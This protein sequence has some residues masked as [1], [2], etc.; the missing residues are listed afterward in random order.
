M[1]GLAKYVNDLTRELSIDLLG[2]EYKAKLIPNMRVHNYLIKDR[3]KI[4]FNKNIC[5][6]FIH[7]KEKIDTLIYEAVTEVDI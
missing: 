2:I 6:Q 4:H 5:E 1:K 3:N 7:E